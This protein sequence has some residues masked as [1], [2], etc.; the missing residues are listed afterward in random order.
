METS[1]DL[2]E[3]LKLLNAH[4]VEFLVVGGYA[5]AFHG[6][7]RYTGD[8]D[9]LVRPEAENARRILAALDDFGFGSLEVDEN[10]FTTA[11]RV[12]QLGI[13]P[14]RIDL[15]TSITGVGWEEAFANCVDGELGGVPVKYI[16][17]ADFIAN[18]R[19][20]G[21]NKDLADIDAINEKD[22]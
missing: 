6:A 4:K 18:K 3:L 22:E 11:D 2:K 7:P 12:L 17:R 21:R 10:D 14:A 9:M 1:E 8:L 15:M 20:I 13:A 5:L 19:A 16:G